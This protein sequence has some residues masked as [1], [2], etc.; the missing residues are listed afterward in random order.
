MNFKIY[1]FKIEF[2]WLISNEIFI[3]HKIA[4]RALQLSSGPNSIRDNLKSKK[5]QIS[6][7]ED[8]KQN[9]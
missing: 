9:F 3:N 8:L 5:K 7:F 1:A 2:I 4:D 6:K